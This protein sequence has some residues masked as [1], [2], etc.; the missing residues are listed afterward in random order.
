MAKRLA[1]LLLLSAA[2]LAVRA[3]DDDVADEV[4]A[5]P[6]AA[7]PSPAFLVIAKAS[8][9]GLPLRRRADAPRESSLTSGTPAL[10]ELREEEVLPREHGALT[11]GVAP[12]E[13]AGPPTPWLPHL[14]RLVHR[15]V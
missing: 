12:A 8:A 2:L 4:E 1:R 11:S 7:A 3:Q 15:L 14:G 5:A 13:S 9:P 10:A 6:A